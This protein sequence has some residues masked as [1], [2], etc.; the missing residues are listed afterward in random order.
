MASTI[1][2]IKCPHCGRSAI[3]DHYYKTDEKTIICYR[4]G[5]YY[6]RKVKDFTTSP[7]QFTEEKCEGYGVFILMKKDGNREAT[8]FNKKIPQEK[9]S[10]YQKEFSQDDMNQA[11]SFL[12]TYEEGVFTI[13]CG[14]PSENFHLPFEQYKINML[15]KYGLD[16]FNRYL[17]PIEE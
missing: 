11:K 7:I 13:H 17:V 12:V 6:S 10:E 2:A 4:C 15:E 3:E 16:D 14:I 1:C 5:Y 8:I 9:I